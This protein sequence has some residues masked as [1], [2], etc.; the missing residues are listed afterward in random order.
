MTN[1]NFDNNV[2]MQT[3]FHLLGDQKEQTLSNTQIN[4]T[5]EEILMTFHTLFNNQEC[6][7]IMDQICI[8]KYKMNLNQVLESSDINIAEM[9]QYSENDALWV[10]FLTLIYLIVAPNQDKLGIYLSREV[11]SLIKN[12]KKLDKALR[13]KLNLY[14]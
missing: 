8:A 9:Q 1:D 4:K 12:I 3:L 10:E 7:A 11:S 14:Y 13:L 5:C 6:K 2:D